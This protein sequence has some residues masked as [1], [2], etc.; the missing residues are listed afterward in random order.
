ML[1]KVSIL[2]SDSEHPIVTYLLK[3]INQSISLANF[4]LAYDSA[5]LNGGDILFLVSCSQFINSD[6]RRMYRSTLVLHASDLP[7][8]RGWSP[9][10]WEILEGKQKLTVSLIEAEDKI[11]TGDIW[12]KRIFEIEGH[13]LWDEINERLFI[14][15]IE[16]MEYAILNH[17]EIKPLK[18]SQTTTPTYYE[19]RTPKDSEVDPTQPLND[20]FNKIRVCDPARFPAFF[21]YKGH[22]IKIILEKGND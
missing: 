10:I 5:D 21:Y 11:D 15:E 7:L 19:K 20:L 6:I 4:E 17:D 3:W 14:I 18:Q 9:H 13:L 12:G 22:K 2:C 1:K 8:G 16:L